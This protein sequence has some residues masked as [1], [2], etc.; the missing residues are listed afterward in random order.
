MIQ[1]TPAGQVLVIDL[2]TGA[3]R[4]TIDLKMPLARTPVCDESARVLYVVAEKD[5]LFVL[6][7]DPIGCAAVEY[8]GHA[9]GSV[10][11]PPARVGRYLVVAENHK[12]NE[13]RWRVFLLDE[14]GTRLKAVQQLPVVG[15]TWGTPAFSGSV[16]WAGGDRGA[17]AAYAVGAYGEK[18]PLRLIA[19]NNADQA[20]SGPAFALARSER[21]LLIGSGRSG[22]YELNPERGKLAAS[23]TLAEAGP[24]LAP[25]QFAGSRLVLTQQNT[26][27]PGVALWCVEPKT[28]AVRWRT[29]LGTPWPSPPVAGAEGGRLTS[30][31]LDARALASSAARL[32][33]GGL[34]RVPFPRPGSFRL[35]PEPLARVEG[36]GWTAVVPAL[37]SATMLV[38][39]KTRAIS[40]KSACP[41][42]SGRSRSPG[43]GNCSSRA[44]TAGPT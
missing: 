16:L 35:P 23:W 15:W 27:G 18:D 14:D 11:C 33:K 32:A 8:L 9:P 12:L 6:T 39:S 38:R 7:R 2:P 13:G 44:T 36:D 31:G 19:R 24:A 34:R 17:F 5:C 43:G 4:A 41:R 42:R 30:L 37:K 26:E 25:P 28:G 3:L 21:E 40:R 22:R 20:A 1:T 29:V 10:V